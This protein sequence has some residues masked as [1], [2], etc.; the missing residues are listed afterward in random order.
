[1]FG[2]AAAAYHGVRHPMNF[3][4]IFQ[5]TLLLVMVGC[6]TQPNRHVRLPDMAKQPTF[7]EEARREQLLG[8]WFGETLTNDGGTRKWLIER[9]DDGTYQ[10]QFRRILGSGQSETITEAGFWGVSG[11]VYF[12][13]MKGWVDGG[14]FH[15]ADPADATL[16]DA[17]EVVEINDEKFRYRNLSTG[18]EYAVRRVG[19]EFVLP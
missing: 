10:V 8:R 1:M 18:S 12:T 3:C 7:A 15:P 9:S 13:I 5:L 17:Y 2:R 11:P 6:A 19:A 16:Y 4:R 14:S